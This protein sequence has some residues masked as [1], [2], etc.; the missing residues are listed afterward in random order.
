MVKQKVGAILV[1]VGMQLLIFGVICS[2]RV[3]ISESS[4]ID[5]RNP[6]YDTRKCLL[7]SVV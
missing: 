7:Q 5:T 4:I 2:Q 6:V 1:I 3:Y